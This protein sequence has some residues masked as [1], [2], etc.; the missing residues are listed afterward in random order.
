ML[1]GWKIKEKSELCLVYFQLDVIM[2]YAV[3]T[4]LAWWIGTRRH[5]VSAVWTVLNIPGSGKT[6]LCAERMV[7][8]MR[9]AAILG[10]KPAD[11]EKPLAWHIRANALV[12]R[13][14]PCHVKNPLQINALFSAHSSLV[15]RKIKID[16]GA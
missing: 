8:S 14:S 4:A 11:R 15:V 12:S 16:Q 6:A 1:C 13:T 5:T 9:V 3:K 2:W 10:W 7:Y